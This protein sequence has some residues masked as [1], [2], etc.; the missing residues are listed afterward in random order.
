MNSPLI[1]FQKIKPQE[2]IY[3]LDIDGHYIEQ[4][5]DKVIS[6]SVRDIEHIP[7]FRFLVAHEFEQIFGIKDIL[8]NALKES[9]TGAVL[10]KFRLYKPQ[11]DID[12]KLSTALAYLLGIPNVDPLSGK[13]YATFTIKHTDTQ[14][15]ELLR[16]YEAF[17]LHT[18][19]AYMKKVPDWI[20][21]MKMAE[22]AAR[23]G[24]SKLLHI[25]CWD[26]FDYFYNHPINTRM[27]KFLSNPNSNTTTRYEE[28]DENSSVYAPLLKVENNQK[29]IRFINRF[30]HPKNLEEAQFIHKIQCS[31]ESSKNSLEIDIPVGCILVINNH[32][33]LHGRNSFEVDNDL[34]RKLMRQRGN[35]S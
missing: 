23:G 15:P 1:N 5:L 19:G 21:F 2:Q 7:Y 20:F 29:S 16:Q 28:N 11:E 33:W 17:K 32:R 14:M 27:V 9:E 34:M 35:W 24:R 6:I 22:T 12:I 31:L 30:I 10:I 18:D 25:N 26:D 13:H 8:L 3:L 4:Y